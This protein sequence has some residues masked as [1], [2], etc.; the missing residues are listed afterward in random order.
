MDAWSDWSQVSIVHPKS[1]TWIE[2]GN[3]RNN[4][5]NDAAW[6]MRPGPKSRS[7]KG[8][9]SATKCHPGHLTIATLMMKGKIMAVAEHGPWL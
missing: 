6:K 7:G 9:F 4:I 1:P 8:D 2:S 3:A 5:N